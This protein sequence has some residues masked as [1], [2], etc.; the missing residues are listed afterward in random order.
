VAA[1]IVRDFTAEAV[2]RHL[3]IHDWLMSRKDA[4]VLRSPAGFLV[5]SIR[6]DY[7]PPKG[8]RTPE[9]RAR[10]AVAADRDRA[11]AVEGHRRRDDQ[12]R[13]DEAAQAFVWDH[14]DG[15]TPERQAATWGEALAAAVPFLADQFRRHQGRSPDD[16]RRYR[17]LILEGFLRERLGLDRPTG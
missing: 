17:R 4:R 2:R 6:R 3:D 14:W 9:E 12:R 15:L 8:Y 13:R 11:S 10:N 5:Q 1:E 7:A 16:E